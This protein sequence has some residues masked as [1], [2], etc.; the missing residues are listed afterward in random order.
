MSSTAVARKLTV[1]LVASDVTSL[2]VRRFN[3]EE[4]LES[5][6]RYA[7][8]I[9]SAFAGQEEIYLVDLIARC[10]ETVIAVAAIATDSQPSVI[11]ALDAE[12][13]LAVV[14]GVVEVNGSFFARL[15]RTW[16]KM[17]ALFA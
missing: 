1:E 14:E 17:R 3:T 16:G 9:A 7:L 4:A 10:R 15:P 8:E 12:D 6:P 2:T 11:R 13:F 5:I